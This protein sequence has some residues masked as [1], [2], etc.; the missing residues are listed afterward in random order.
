MEKSFSPIYNTER[1]P[2][3]IKVTSLDNIDQEYI[4]NLAEEVKPENAPAKAEEFFD[5]FSKKLN[6]F[7][8]EM[9]KIP[10]EKR[11]VELERLAKFRV[12]SVR[13][14][15]ESIKKELS[16]A[17][18]GDLIDE[19]RLHGHVHDY[20]MSKVSFQEI[21]L[22]EKNG[23]TRKNV[24]NLERVVSQQYLAQS[25]I[26][27]PEIIDKIEKIARQAK[28]GYNLPENE[29]GGLVRGVLGL[30]AGYQYY[31]QKG[32]RV[33]FSDKKADAN[34]KSDLF[35]VD[36]ENLSEEQKKR[37]G[38]LNYDIKD[39]QRLEDD[40]RE[41]I[42]RIQTKCHKDELGET[43]EISYNHKKKDYDYR[44]GD[45]IETKLD[46]KRILSYV[47]LS[48]ERDE[49]EIFFK[50]FCEGQDYN[51]KYIS[52]SQFDAERQTK[53]V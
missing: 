20:L 39:T 5:L 4:K 7:G 11:K 46:L 29:I 27:K 53:E 19:I 30:A 49:V 48:E 15:I 10:L 6:K 28:E 32:Y 17:D 50:H 31:N 45:K 44:L 24:T 37:I 42:I 26:H 12:L 16:S 47:R 8:V 36:Y 41:K 34:F 25:V 1:N 13:A 43:F 2:G 3:S 14:L 22:A 21:A 35:A 33:V 51:G 9:R 23:K 40:L 18:A 38:E 52:F